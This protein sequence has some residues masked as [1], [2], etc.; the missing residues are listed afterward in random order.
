LTSR[1]TVLQRQR[2]DIASLHG[3]FVFNFFIHCFAL[4]W[5]L[6]HYQPH[7]CSLPS[8]IFKNKSNYNQ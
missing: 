4:P 2:F 8:L 6:S 5:R 1:C 3:Q 7:I